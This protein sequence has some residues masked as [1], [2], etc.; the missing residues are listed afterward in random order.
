SLRRLGAGPTYVVPLGN[1]ARL[2]FADP[3]KIVEL[4]WWQSTTIG[5]VEITLVPARH[6]S[7]RAPWNRNDT[8]WGGYVVRGPEGAV[9]HS[10]DTGWGDHFAE[11][12]Q[13]CGSIDWAML[14][15]GAYAPRWFMQPQHMDPDEARRAGHATVTLR[16]P[17]A[18]SSFSTRARTSPCSTI[19]PS[20]T[21]PPTPSDC[22][23]S[24]AQRSS[25]TGLTSSFSTTV[26]SLP[27]RPLRS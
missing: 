12:A 18:S 23:S 26:T 4:D 6:W 15:I 2:D 25:S 19:A 27:P 10:G 24:L 17:R 5:A 13:R 7:M 3:D 8:L 16:T 22:L 1:G 9:Y 11:L 20:S 14:P 21:R